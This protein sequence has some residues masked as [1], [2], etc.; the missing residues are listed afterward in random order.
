MGVE[1][2]SSF[3]RSVSTLAA[4]P[5]LRRT[6]RFVGGS[7]I[8]LSRQPADAVACRAGTGAAPHTFAHSGGLDD[9][10]NVARAVTFGAPTTVAGQ[11]SW[12]RSACLI[13]RHDNDLRDGMS[14][15]HDHAEDGP[16][17]GRPAMTML[18]RR[19]PFDEASAKRIDDGVR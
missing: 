6:L 7:I 12:P 17:Y 8:F 3:A 4:N 15:R 5:T 2:L 10:W 16:T 18:G 14:A 19:M 11:A 1:G 13:A 9:A